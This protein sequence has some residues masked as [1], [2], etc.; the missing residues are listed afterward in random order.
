MSDEGMAALKGWV[1]HLLRNYALVLQRNVHQ[2]K[3]LVKVGKCLSLCDTSPVNQLQKQI[4]ARS[5]SSCYYASSEFCRLAKKNWL[6]ST[7]YSVLLN[8][9]GNEP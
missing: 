2:P 9:I 5:Y 7:M 4:G 3:K 1:V 8:V 6:A